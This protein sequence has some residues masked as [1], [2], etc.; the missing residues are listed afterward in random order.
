M[1]C[2]S[3]L[4]SFNRVKRFD[5]SVTRKSWTSKRSLFKPRALCCVPPYALWCSILPPAQGSRRLSLTHVKKKKKHSAQTTL[6]WLEERKERWC[7]DPFRLVKPQSEHRGNMN[8]SRHATHTHTHACGI[9]THLHTHANLHWES[10]SY[11]GNSESSALLCHSEPKSLWHW[12]TTGL[13][14]CSCV[15]LQV[16]A[17]TIYLGFICVHLQLYFICMHSLVWQKQVCTWQS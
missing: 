12:V 4:H 15:C 8:S 16:W 9:E 10:G 14:V 11:N 3:D 7:C 1:S 17:W 13:P 2:S 6:F 5:S